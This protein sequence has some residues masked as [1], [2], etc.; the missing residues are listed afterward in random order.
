MGA[1]LTSASSEQSMQPRDSLPGE[2]DVHIVPWLDDRTASLV[3]AIVAS[4]AHRH[5]E[6]VAAILYGSVARHEERPLTDSAPSDVDLLLLFDVDHEQDRLTRNQTL[7]ICESIGQALDRYLYPPREVQT[8]LVLMSLAGWD[9]TFI[10]N[11]AHDGI[12]L[13]SRGPLPAPFSAISAR[14]PRLVGTGHPAS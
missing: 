14:T 6:F 5:P 1:Q 2:A 3:R 7:A 9:P 12:L 13:W 10:E 4:V 8:I 11:V